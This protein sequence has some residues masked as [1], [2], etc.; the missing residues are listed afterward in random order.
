MHA[1]TQKQ[2]VRVSSHPQKPSREA[3][4]NNLDC[5]EFMLGDS[6][7]WHSQ[8]QIQPPEGLPCTL[9]CRAWAVRSQLAATIKGPAL[10]QELPCPIATRW[11]HC[12]NLPLASWLNAGF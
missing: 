12:I 4:G 3:R 6:D 8:C 11:V 10:A 9:Q 2:F 1:D 5:L 7:A